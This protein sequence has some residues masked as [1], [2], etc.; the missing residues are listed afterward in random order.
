[1]YNKKY[2]CSEIRNLKNK[3]NIFHEDVLGK[4]CYLAYLNAG[5]RGW[6][7]CDTGEE[8]N[9]VHRIHTSEIKSIKYYGN[10]VTVTTENTEYTFDLITEV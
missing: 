7:L 5:E 9:P 4:V 3:Y 8:L 6:F 2:R 1:M 10:Q